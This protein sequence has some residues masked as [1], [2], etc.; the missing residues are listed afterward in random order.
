LEPV[1]LAV[2]KDSGVAWFLLLDGTDIMYIMRI[3]G[4][5]LLAAGFLWLATWCAGSADSLTRSIGAEHLKHYPG[6]AKYSGDEV[7][8]AIRS[9]LTEYHDNARGVT[10]P[11]ALMLVGGVLLDIAR[12]RIPRRK[13]Q[14]TISLEGPVEL[15]NDKLVIRIPL[16]VGG[17]HLA[18][19]AAKMGRIEGDHLNVTIPPR[20]AKR[21]NIDVGT[22]VSVD[23]HDGKFT[24]AR[25][26]V[27]DDEPIKLVQVA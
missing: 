13:V 12:R 7:C 24:L 3:T 17:D 5:I 14:D 19:F 23:N 9:V 1:R 2:G 11:A 20:L 25:S 26:A 4:Y 8:D 22:I 18:P 16:A 6:F 21:L 10:L 27:N 15:F